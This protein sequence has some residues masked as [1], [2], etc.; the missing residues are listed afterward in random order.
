MKAPDLYVGKQL[1]CGVGNPIA[2]GVGPTQIRVSGYVEG[3]LMVG[4]ESKF[5]GGVDNAT[6]MLS[7]TIN[8]DCPLAG[9]VPA[10]ILK[11]RSSLVPSPTDVIIGDPAG[12]VGVS[13]YCKPQPFSVIAEVVNFTAS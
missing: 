7:N 10:S 1:F 8:R 6:L 5:G 2:L 13:F 12:A 11:I 9:G 3:P 4:A